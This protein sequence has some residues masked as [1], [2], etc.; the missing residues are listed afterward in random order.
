MTEMMIVLVAGLLLAGVLPLL[1]RRRAAQPVRVRS[2]R[3]RRP[4]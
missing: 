2:S 3:D 4:G 1:S